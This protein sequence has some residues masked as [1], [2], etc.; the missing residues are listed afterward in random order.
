MVKKIKKRW[1]WLAIIIIGI[2]AL[3]FWFKSQAPVTEYTTVEVKLGTL[4]Q[5]VSETGTVKPVKRLDLNFPQSG[6]ISQILV[7]VGE[8]V[9]KGQVL[10]ELDQST[11]N[12]RA[13]E[14][15]A[16]LAGALANQQKLISGATASELAV[17]EAQVRQAR[18]AY[19]G[20]VSDYDKT[21]QSTAEN[22]SQAQKKLSDLNDE[23]SA[24]PTALEQA[25]A[26]AKLN[27]S[28]GQANYLQALTNSENVFTNA[29][30]YNLAVANTAL[31]KIKGLL[32]DESLDDVFSVR[33]TS[34]RTLTQVYYN[35]AREL[36]EAADSAL[37]AAKSERT[38]ANY[39]NLHTQLSSYLNKIFSN[40][41]A[42]YSG[43]ENTVTS[44]GFPQSSL[45]AYKTSIN[46]QIS[47]I[48]SSI[49]SQ[50]TAKYNLDNSFLNYKNNTAS[51]SEALRQA[52]IA[53]T[54]GRLAAE[55]ALSSAQLAADKQVA[56]AKAVMDNSK[57][58]WGVADRQLAKLKSGARSED[59]NLAAAQ[60]R[61]AQA[62]LD[63]IT[64]QREDSQLVAP[65]AG[66]VIGI[67]YEAGE[68]FSAAKPF[69]TMLTE[70]NYEIDVD[71]SET[72]ITKVKV[73]DEATISFDALGESRQFS[74][75]VYS[76]EPSATVIQGVIYYKAK[77]VL[78]A[79]EANS[80]SQLIKPEMT[81][82]VV[83]KTAAK[84]D[85]IIIPNRAV[86]DRNGQGKFVRILDNG[87]LREVPVTLGLSGDDGLVEVVDG[88]LVPGQLAVTF[89][90]EVGK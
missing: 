37:K 7:K 44:S 14:A 46:A 25:V 77:I 24:T 45:D 47:A 66:Q 32:D 89:V 61:Q 23:T 41:N 51:L 83:I 28:S 50:Q 64:K 35:E 79:T 53:L 26:I 16:S 39:N 38:E 17:L 85:V 74:G 5:T 18:S 27:L 62:S 22:V 73:G 70:D 60:V 20:A 80:D 52:E 75:S 34:Y 55:N 19:E 54:E 8:T 56:A 12:I 86:I 21:R 81:A 59:I 69:L 58:S 71:I 40:L 9:A 43:L 67:N 76:I 49:S 68:Q 42:A 72:D 11:L 88:E 33:N 90:K 63:L 57:E 2:A 31:D 6:L 30:E 36:R 29:A 84:D 13:Q 1:W 15:E 78:A 4:I 65:L 3:F 48:N 10:G 82:N 87:L